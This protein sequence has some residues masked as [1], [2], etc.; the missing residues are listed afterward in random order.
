MTKNSHKGRVGGPRPGAGAKPKMKDAT[1]VL[2]YVHPDTARVLADLA[3]E[4]AAVVDEANRQVYVR[5]RD[6]RITRS[7]LVRA[8][9]DIYFQHLT[10]SPRSLAEYFRP[11][12]GRA[13]LV[14]L[15]EGVRT[16]QER[17]DTYIAKALKE[18]VVKLADLINVEIK[19]DNRQQVLK[20]DRDEPVVASELYRE[21]V[22]QFLNAYEGRPEELAHDLRPRLGRPKDR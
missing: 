14:D 21:A 9:I 20:K 22:R 10:A 5:D 7:E 4:A 12:L 8:A 17:I 2:F 3:A 1:R 13:K 15:N 11:Y 18:H 6:E 19:H 16:R